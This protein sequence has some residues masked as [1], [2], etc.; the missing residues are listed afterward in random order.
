MKEAEAHPKIKLKGIEIGD[1]C[2]A[3]HPSKNIIRHHFIYIGNGLIIERVPA[4]GNQENGKPAR[5]L[6][7][8]IYQYIDNDIR[9]DQKRGLLSDAYHAINSIGKECN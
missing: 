9:V 5:L 8:D 4:E 2:S 3:N 1:H 6:K 7:G